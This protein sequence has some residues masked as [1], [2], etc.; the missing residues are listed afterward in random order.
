MEWF[1]KRSV[2]L[3]WINV[4][5]KIV[6]ITRNLTLKCLFLWRRV[7]VSLSNLKQGLQ[8]LLCLLFTILSVLIFRHF[9]VCFLSQRVSWI[10]SIALLNAP[11]SLWR[12]SFD[13]KKLL[14]GK[15]Y[16]LRHPLFLSITVALQLPILWCYII[17]AN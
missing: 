3:I 13:C 6:W 5:Q 2:Y 9:I 10:W 12:A 14:H 16:H 17:N 8:W 7:S 1:S 15:L 4:L 11:L